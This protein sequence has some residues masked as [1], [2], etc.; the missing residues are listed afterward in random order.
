MA[1]NPDGTR[2]DKAESLRAQAARCRRLASHTTDREIARKL[3][4]LA[5][6]FD[7][8]AAELETGKRFS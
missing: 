3:L 6:E 7:Q 5:D 8:R 1:E 2:D 4:E